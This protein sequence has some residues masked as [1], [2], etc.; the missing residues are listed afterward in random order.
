MLTMAMLVI[1]LNANVSW[2]PAVL[3]R[4]HHVDARTVGLL[5]GPVFLVFGIIGTLAAGAIIG[6]SKESVVN[7]TFRFMRW[8]VL[9]A[10]PAAALGP[11]APSLWLKLPLVAVTLLC[12]SS[13]LALSSLPLLI[14]APSEVRAQALAVLALVT[15][16]VGTGLG[17]LL[18]GVLSDLL[19]GANQPLSVALAIVGATAALFAALML[20]SLVRRSREHHR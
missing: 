13:G 8:C 18:V 2:M 16:L 6:R 14:I 10:L 11:L 17:P 5:F 1:L 12:T 19:R 9:I 4:A 7:R 20:H 15:A 3:M